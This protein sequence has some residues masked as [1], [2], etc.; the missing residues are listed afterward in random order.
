MFLVWLITLVLNGSGIAGDFT[1][2]LSPFNVFLG[3]SVTFF[4]GILA[5]IIPAIAASKL[6]P[7]EAIRPETFLSVLQIWR[8]I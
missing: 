8:A 5:G 7:V 6:D 3:F 2:V 1:F 4:I